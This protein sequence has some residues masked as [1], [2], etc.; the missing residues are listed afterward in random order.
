MFMSI[1][2]RRTGAMPLWC[3]PLALLGAAPAMAQP[4]PASPPPPAPVLY[5]AKADVDAAIVRAVSALQP[6][7]NVAGVSLLLFGHYRANLE[8]RIGPAGASVHEGQIELFQVVEG[9]GTLTMGGTL[10]K[11]PAG[12]VVKGG[13]ARHVAAGD[14]FVVPAGTPHAFNQIDGHLA[15]ISMKLPAQ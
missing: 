6:G 1:S 15:L 3:A 10:D 5:A 4:A 11:G 12:N 2:I 7:Q 14:V 13:T 9:S 8:Y